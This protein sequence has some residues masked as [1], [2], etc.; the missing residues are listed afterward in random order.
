MKALIVYLSN[1]WTI[2]STDDPEESMDDLVRMKGGFVQ[3][4]DGEGNEVAV[5]RDRIV[6]AKIKNIGEEDRG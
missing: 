6:Y 5:N 2:F 3:M 4:T 1:G